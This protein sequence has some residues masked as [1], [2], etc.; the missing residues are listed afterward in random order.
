MPQLRTGLEAFT[1]HVDRFGATGK[2]WLS[3]LEAA[4]KTI[5]G[6]AD[7]MRYSPRSFSIHYASTQSLDTAVDAAVD[8]IG[9]L[10][11]MTLVAA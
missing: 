7:D 2:T 10:R 11:S 3:G 6:Y 5:A 1:P 9:A 8:V 4:T